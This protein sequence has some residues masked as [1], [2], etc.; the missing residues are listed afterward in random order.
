MARNLKNRLL[1]TALVMSMITA[2][3]GL[4]QAQEDEIDEVNPGNTAISAAEAQAAASAAHPGAS[5]LTVEYDVEG[6]VAL[7]EVEFDDNM[8]VKVDASTGA[9]IVTEVRDAD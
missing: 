7:F 1:A 2:G 9:I 8:D 5:V 6:G 3:A 4:A